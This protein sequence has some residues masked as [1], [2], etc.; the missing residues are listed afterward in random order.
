MYLV[1]IYILCLIV[2]NNGQW[3]WMITDNCPY[4][5]HSVISIFNVLITDIC[6]WF[7]I[8]P[9]DIEI[10]ACQILVETNVI[11]LDIWTIPL[12]MSSFTFRDTACDLCRWRSMPSMGWSGRISTAR[13]QKRK[14]NIIY[15]HL[16]AI[17]KQRLLLLNCIFFHFKLDFFIT[18]I[19]K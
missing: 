11:N 12:F 9:F 17:H 13:S 6:F 16:G 15:R 7:Q 8:K 4:L 19:H 18:V 5:W 1:Q 2:S 14:G 3:Y 10:V